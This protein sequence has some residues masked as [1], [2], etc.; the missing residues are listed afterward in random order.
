MPDCL[1]IF[2]FRK[3][4]LMIKKI[5]LWS[6]FALL[7]LFAVVLFKTITFSSVQSKEVAF[8]APAVTERSLANFKGAINI[9]T[10]S[11]E[12]ASKIDTNQFLAFHDYLEKTYPLAHAQLKREKVAHFSLL[13]T[14]EGKNPQLKPAILMAHQDV[15]PIE[16]A[17]QKMWTVDPFSGIVKDNYIWGRGTADD[18]I[19]LVSIM[20]AVEKLV[21]ENFKPERTV[22]LVFGHDEE[23]GGRG[24][25]AVAKLMKDRNI[26]A[27]LVLD[28]GGVITKEK[29][30][31]MTQPIALLGT[32]EKGYMSLKLTAEK[33]GGHSSMPDKETSIDILAKAIM[34][35]RANPFE[36]KFSVPMQGFIRALGP[37]MPFLQK[38]IFANT[39]LFKG[40][41]VGVYEK[42]GAGNAMVRTTLVPT[43]MSAGVKDNVVPTVATAYVNLRLLPGDKGADIKEQVIKL[44]ND[45]RVTVEYKNGFFTEASAV[46]DENGERFKDVAYAI[47]H[48]YPETL[49]S[50][51]LMIGA[52]DSRK[53][54]GISSNIIKFSPMIDPIGFHGIDERVSVESFQTS[55]WFYEQLIREF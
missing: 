36:P 40:V 9:Q 49:V 19:N 17:T 46:T 54:E 55:L 23:I 24:A 16:E 4:P 32:A 50:P 42:S 3:I 22:Y 14:W 11:R 47:Q 12:D 2:D 33:S 38:M 29:V 10:I 31:G 37:E 35:L 41:L 39:W 7:V 15:V 13:Y 34:K 18:K 52:T 28:E 5:L 30:P 20:E 48:A 53:F 1:F 44:I 27:D 8:P 43:I 21:A 25:E 26:Q 51:F 45:P 6:L